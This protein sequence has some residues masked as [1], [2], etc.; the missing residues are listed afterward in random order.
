MV[1]QLLRGQ[2]LEEDREALVEALAPALP[3]DV[4]EAD[5]DRRDAGAHTELQAAAAE[6]IEHADLVDEPQWVIERQAVD[7]RPQTQRRGALR[8]GGEEDARRGG[9]AERRAVV[10]GEVVGVEPGVLVALD[11]R[12]ALLELLADR[13]P[14]LVDLV[15]DP[16][17]HVCRL[18]HDRERREPTAG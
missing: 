13:Q 15:E 1:G 4:E 5:L 8:R 11:E 17:L 10:L 16:E 2:A 6:V 9:V 7:E 12:E 18:P 14:A 3:V